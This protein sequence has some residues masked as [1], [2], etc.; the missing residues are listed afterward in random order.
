MKQVLQ[1]GP[2]VPGREAL[3][4]RSLEDFLGT[5]SSLEEEDRSVKLEESATREVLRYPLPGTPREDGK[6]TGS[7][8]GAGT[9]WVRL[10]R[11]RGAG[12]LEALRARFTEPCSRSLAEREWNLLCRL[13]GEGVGTPEPLAVGS[14]GGGFARRSFLVTRELE[15]V[16]SLE[17]W[18]RANPKGEFRRQGLV[19]LAAALRRLLHSG[20]H[21]PGLGS[22][23]IF[24]ARPKEICSDSEEPVREKRMR[25]LPAVYLT[26][27]TGGVLGELPEGREAARRISRI[28][29][30]L[31]HPEQLGERECYSIFVRALGET[32]SKEKRRSLWR[33]IAGKAS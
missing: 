30:T 31:R 25:R 28:H 14:T 12:F 15:N 2:G 27:T 3:G 23:S 18:L 5:G 11:Y 24:V 17:D 19:A 7:P 13:R 21:L 32:F 22:N 16:D 1:F 33:E 29:A 26:E 6:L 8:R 9:G 10:I 20:V 4:G